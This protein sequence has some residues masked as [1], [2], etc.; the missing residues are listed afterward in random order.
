MA[1]GLRANALELFQGN[2]G[3]RHQEHEQR[4]H[5]IRERYRRLDPQIR[6]RHL[7]EVEARLVAIKRTAQWQN[8]QAQ[9]HRDAAQQLF[10]NYQIGAKV[11]AARNNAPRPEVPA[12]NVAQAA[13]PQR[14][15]GLSVAGRNAVNPIILDRSLVGPETLRNLREDNVFKPLRMGSDLNMLGRAGEPLQQL[16]NTGLGPPPDLGLFRLGDFVDLEVANRAAPPPARGGVRQTPASQTRAQ[17]GARL[18][19]QAAPH[20]VRDARA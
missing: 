9:V 6:E 4:I 16:L 5:E 10:D 12:V 14:L 1:D 7:A 11:L 19:Q 20:H 15:R 3:P 17:P 8:Q 13:L 2:W 18:N